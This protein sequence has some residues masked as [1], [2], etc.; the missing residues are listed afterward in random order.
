MYPGGAKGE[1]PPGKCG[2]RGDAAKVRNPGQR[3]RGG[4]DQRAGDG[5][6]WRSECRS[7]RG[8]AGRW[9]TRRG[10]PQIHRVLVCGKG[11]GKGSR[12][13]GDEEAGVG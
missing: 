3:R 4:S 12:R 5:G 11:G 6:S 9:I 1:G 8:P 2:E 10:D 13:F 7:E